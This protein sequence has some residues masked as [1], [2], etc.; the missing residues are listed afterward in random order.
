M[1]A[2]S[3]LIALM[4][5]PHLYAGAPQNE[6]R[7]AAT[8][9][10]FRTPPVLDGVIQK[11]EWKHAVQTSGFV[12]LRN[13]LDHR[14]GSTYVGFTEQA[15]YIAVVSELP[16]DK[17]LQ[18]KRTRRDSRV[19]FDDGIE[20]WVDAFQSKRESDQQGSYPVFQSIINSIGIAQDSKHAPGSAP[21]TGWNGDWTVANTIDKDNMVWVFEASIPWSDF[22]RDKTDTI[23]GE[24]VG[25][26]VARNYKRAWSQATSMHVKRGFGGP[27]GYPKFK[28]T[29][30]APSVHITSIGDIK[31]IRE[32]GIDV[33]MRIFNPGKATKARVSCHAT[34]TTMPEVTDVDLV[35]LPPNDYAE[36]RFTVS[37]D[38]FHA[39]ARHHV[40]MQV[41]SEEGEDVFFRHDLNWSGNPSFNNHP[42][43]WTVKVGPNPEAAVRTAYLPSYNVLR[44]KIDPSEL[45]EEAHDLKEA[46]VSL[47]NEQEEQLLREEVS[48][49]ESPAEEAFEIPDLPDG[50][51]TVRVELKGYDGAVFDRTITREHYVWENNRL[52][53]TNT[54][55]EPFE[56][57]EVDG[58]LLSV[59]MRNHTIGH[60]GF[61]ESI[62]ICE[63][64]NRDNFQ[65]LLAGPIQL[66][67]DDGETLQ[68][69]GEFTEVKDHV[70]TYEAEGKHPAVSVQV[71]TITEYDGCQRVE[72]TLEPGTEGTELQKMWLDIPIKDEMAPLW[73]CT[74]TSIRKNPA[75]STPEGQGLVWDSREFPDGSWYGNFKPY[76]WFGAEERGLCWFADNDKNWVL[77][78][79][80]EDPEASSA[81]LEVFRENGVLTLRVHFVQK[82]VT[83]ESP[84]TI[85]FGLMASPAKPMPENWRNILPA[86]MWIYGV[87]VP[88][89]LTHAGMGS[90]YW[91]CAESMS[92][93]YPLNRDMSIL[94]MMQEARLSG[95]SRERAERYADIWARRHNIEELMPLPH[96]RKAYDPE[97]AKKLVRHSLTSVARRYKKHK[98]VDF[99]TVY[100]E[101]F[102]GVSAYHPETRVFGNEWSGRYTTR[103]D[104]PPRNLSSLPRSYIDFAC[105]YAAEFIRRGIGIYFDNTFPKTGYDLLT[106][107]AYRLPNGAIQPTA[108]MWSHRNYFRRI[109]TLHRQLAPDKTKPM[110]MLHMTNSHV[111]PTM[112]WNDMNY[113]LEW[114]GSVLPKQR[115]FSPELLRTESIGLQTGTIPT[116]LAAKG[117]RGHL[118]FFGSM[119]VHEVRSWFTNK[120]ARSMLQHTL[121][122][123]YGRGADVFNYWHEDYP[124]TASDDEVKT[125]LLERDNELMILLTTWNSRPARVRLEIDTRALGVSPARACNAET[126]E[127][128]PFDGTTVTL[129]VEGYDVRLI[130]LKQ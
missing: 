70:V 118:T 82:P 34:S 67:V 95:M 109:W 46:T 79:D 120:T 129:D 110:M 115:A 68:G 119:M 42:L 24:R 56:P 125:L 116:A 94:N 124:M 91:G 112:V 103:K 1:I 31:D 73:H 22:G 72:M 100:W 114:L 43:K 101:E 66:K 5:I 11:D 127:G 39:D 62:S 49:E 52:G 54:I 4:C 50:D 16:P 47:L 88:G 14:L 33:Q 27:G 90:T 48:W 41:T 12:S 78:V 35:E 45:E 58:D 86:N 10:R 2:V 21:D 36:Y 75:G 97:Q 26:L 3:G 126:G 130:H 105:W 71:K 38:R 28:L 108:K 55:Y 59:V 93:R 65:E 122:F 80:E 30:N 85:V 104:L 51:Y 57:I 6:D 25:V 74:T 106:T 113:D 92:E 23:T 20:I 102:H 37:P 19:I 8:V 32:G 123:G 83:I 117:C 7:A 121:E 76:I 81:S 96:G 69:T 44:V 64:R 9:S 87:K 128:L 13:N 98:P 15:L 63:N 99:R 53:I 61:W 18:T 60:L 40:N 77:D 107:E 111:V 89:Y 84:R 17:E 29:E